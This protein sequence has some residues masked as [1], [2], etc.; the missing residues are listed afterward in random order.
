MFRMLKLNCLSYKKEQ[1]PAGTTVI[2][3]ANQY[4]ND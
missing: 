4:A 3:V 1:F 2:S